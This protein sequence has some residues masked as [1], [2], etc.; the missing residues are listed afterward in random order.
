ME[1][2]G[3]IV[4]WIIIPGVFECPK[5]SG[6]GTARGFLMFFC[7]GFKLPKEMKCQHLLGYKDFL[8]FTS[9]SYDSGNIRGFL[10]FYWNAM[11]LQG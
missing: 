6:K 10:K 9:P 7:I 4:F 8:Y 5:R 2:L 11:F 3:Q 1:I